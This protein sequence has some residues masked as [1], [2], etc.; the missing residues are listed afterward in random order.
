MGCRG[1]LLESFRSGRAPLDV[2]DERVTSI[3]IK[4]TV[5]VTSCDCL[6]SDLPKLQSANLEGFDTPEAKTMFG[7]FAG[8]EALTDLKIA[9]FDTQNLESA[10]SMF[11]GCSYLK[12][13]DL[14][15]WNTAKVTDMGIMFSDR[16]KLQIC[17]GLFD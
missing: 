6:F 9:K 13:L 5:K 3:V 12:S 8:C 1:A 10:R 7:M 15:G 17:R 14:S 16:S 2:R 11:N 4:S